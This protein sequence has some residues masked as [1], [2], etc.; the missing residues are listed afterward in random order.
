[1]WEGGRLGKWNFFK[2]M[3]GDY[4]SFYRVFEYRDFY[5]GKFRGKRIYDGVFEFFFVF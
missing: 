5:G 4:R 1:M 2:N 3:L